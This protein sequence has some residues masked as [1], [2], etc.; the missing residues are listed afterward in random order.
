[1]SCQFLKQRID[2]KLCVKS[3]KNAT[4]TCA[5]LSEAYGGEAVKNLSVFVWNRGFKGI[6]HVKIT[7]EDNPHHFFQY[8]DYY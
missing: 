3:E 5:M 2:I 6:T 4:D 8:Q 1:M 7:N